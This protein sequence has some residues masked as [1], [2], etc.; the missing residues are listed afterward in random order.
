VP[1]LWLQSMTTR[2][3]SPSQVEVAIAAM[4]KALETDGLPTHS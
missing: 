1:G 4:R 3:P 2:R